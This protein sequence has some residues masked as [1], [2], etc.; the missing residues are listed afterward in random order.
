MTM[1]SPMKQMQVARLS[2][3]LKVEKMSFYLAIVLQLK[4]KSSFFVNSIDGNTMA[5]FL[6]IIVS[7]YIVLLFSQEHVKSKS[8]SLHY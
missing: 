5:N 8:V 2:A 6:H 7:F 1:K 4:S 3:K